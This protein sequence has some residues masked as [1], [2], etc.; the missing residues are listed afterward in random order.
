M[1][2]ATSKASL[3]MQNG[4]YFVQISNATFFAFFADYK[5]S[6]FF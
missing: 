3:Q 6:F 2:L 1:C 5:G 4:P